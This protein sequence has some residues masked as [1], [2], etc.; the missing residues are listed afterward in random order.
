MPA[1]PLPAVA[2]AGS[3]GDGHRSWSRTHWT[4]RTRG[5]G[6]GGRCSRRPRAS[7]AQLPRSSA[8]AVDVL[9]MGR[10][11]GGSRGGGRSTGRS[12]CCLGHRWGT[13]V[14]RGPPVGSPVLPG[15]RV[16]P[17]RALPVRAATSVGLRCG[18]PDKWVLLPVLGRA[19]AFQPFEIPS[20]GRY[21]G[22]TLGGS[23]RSVNAVNKGVA[24]QVMKTSFRSPAEPCARRDAQHSRTSVFP[25]VNVL[26]PGVGLDGW[27]A[28]RGD[29]G[30]V[31]RLRRCG[32]AAA[33]WAGLVRRPPVAAA[34]RRRSP[35]S[36]PAGRGGGAVADL[37]PSCR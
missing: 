27:A 34:R 14:F 5:G 18:V 8:C 21:V 1:H 9:Q 10:A 15:T 3:H 20:H 2:G 36:R 24:G 33:M 32:A 25:L 11:A 12:K 35:G 26:A 22:E 17:V 16:S 4:D 13:P 31:G 6:R 28:M 30:G 37:S 7:R 23:G 29:R 19:L